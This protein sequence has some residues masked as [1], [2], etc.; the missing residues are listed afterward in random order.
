MHVKFHF[1]MLFTFNSYIL[2]ETIVSRI[3]V[4]YNQNLIEI[5]QTFSQQRVAQTKGST[6]PTITYMVIRA[7]S[8]R[9][10]SHDN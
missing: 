4:P 5:L 1:I 8:S 10:S 9:T 6:L 7:P 3:H 2:S